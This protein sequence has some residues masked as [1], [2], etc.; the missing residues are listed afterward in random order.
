M[1]GVTL[2]YAPVRPQTD[3]REHED[4]S[5]I[6]RHPSP[7]EAK[8]RKIH[9]ALSIIAIVTLVILAGRALVLWNNHSVEGELDS[10]WTAYDTR[11]EPYALPESAEHCATWLD[12]SEPSQSTVS[13]ELPGKAELLFFLSRGPNSGQFNI[14][15][16]PYSSSQAIGVTVTAHYTHR[17]DLE[18][19]KACRTGD[20]SKEEHGLLIWTPSHPH[21]RRNLV[22][23]NITVALPQ[24]LK[25]YKDLSTDLALFSHHVGDFF[26]LWSPT[27]FRTLRFNSY[28][29]SI[30][31]GVPGESA[32]IET[33]SAQVQGFFAG[34]K[35]LAVRT[36]N[37]PIHSNAIMLAQAPGSETHIDLETT[38]SPIEAG[39]SVMSDHPKPKLTANI[40]TSNG[41]LNVYGPR[42]PMGD[43]DSSFHLDA[44]TSNAPATIRLHP[45]YEGT[46]DL[47]TS[48][49]KASVKE[50]PGPNRD[51]AGKK[52]ERTVRRT[53]EGPHTE[54]DI[55]W[56]H[57]GK[58]E[59][60]TLARGSVRVFTFNMALLNT[61]VKDIKF[62][63]SQTDFI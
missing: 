35:S 27:F 59:E 45:D 1:P 38:N 19:A 18:Y 56:S 3:N 13:F 21:R 29:A 40:R 63:D 8:P 30:D 5:D 25:E 22:T 11:L 46:F 10:R 2:D 6:I 41:A 58:P 62:Q 54:G 51:P 14:E 49:A 34:V 20:S 42:Q 44:V 23:F 36:S 43:G 39:L 55:F 48:W 17:E 50:A 37:A 52:R 31:F 33:S 7:P 53:E 15:K 57:D 47:E 9:R 60:G 28:D 4:L 24:S 26:D 32:Y 16:A 61:D 12:S